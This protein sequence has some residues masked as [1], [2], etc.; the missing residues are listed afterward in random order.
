[1]TYHNRWEGNIEIALD[2]KREG[3][4]GVLFG[5]KLRIGRLVKGA[6]HRDE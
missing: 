3:T 2:G 5:T 4:I 6:Y 1:V